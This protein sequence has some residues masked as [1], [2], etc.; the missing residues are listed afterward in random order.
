M[1]ILLWINRPISPRAE[2]FNPRLRSGVLFIC[3]KDLF[4]G[5]KHGLPAKLRHRSFCLS[6]RVFSLVDDR[7]T[8]YSP[9]ALFCADVPTQWWTTPNPICS[10]EI[11]AGTTPFVNL[12]VAHIP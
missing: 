5:A 4:V 2:R 10:H 12:T 6:G 8:G 7:R 11:M 1:P 3:A 9:R